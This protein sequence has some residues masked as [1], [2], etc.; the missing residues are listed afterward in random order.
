VVD[1]H[2]LM[3]HRS[4]PDRLA[5]RDAAEEADWAR[6]RPMREEHTRA[7]P[8]GRDPD[9]AVKLID[10]AEFVGRVAGA[11]YFGATVEGRVVAA[12]EL[13][14]NGRVAQI[15]DVA[16]LEPYRGRGLGRAVVL[17]ALE[18]AIEGGNDL[19]F[20]VADSEDWPRHMYEKLGFDAVGYKYTFL[21]SDTHPKANR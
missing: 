18:A 10:A 5:E 9:V 11:R 19:V 17:K 14:S 6:L 1:R 15:E 4:E 3:A 12:S 16:T 13:Y 2:V 7:Q 8:Y 20:L 21:L